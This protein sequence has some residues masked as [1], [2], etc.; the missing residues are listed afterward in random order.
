MALRDP[1]R[2]TCDVRRQDRI[3]KLPERMPRRQRLHFVD[4]ELRL[5]RSFWLPGAATRSARSTIAPRPILMK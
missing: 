4:I 3:G 2:I 5:P 1:G